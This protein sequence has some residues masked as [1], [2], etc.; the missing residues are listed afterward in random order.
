MINHLYHY[1]DKSTGPFRNLSDLEPDAAKQLLADMKQDGKWF[2]GQRS[3][4]YM[5]IRHELECKARQKFLAKG[6]KPVR[7]HPH[8]MTVGRCPWLLSWYPNGRELRIPIEGFDPLTVSFTYGDLFPTMRY[9]DSKPYR[10]QVYALDE[11]ENIIRLYGLP[12][13]WNSEGLLGP[14]RYIEA[15]IWEDRPLEMWIGN[16]GAKFAFGGHLKPI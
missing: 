10:Q 1:Y 15:Q 5:A 16:V 4:D 6:G 7:L 12:Q 3:L 2:A 11:L 8:Y 9:Q 13:D 14:E